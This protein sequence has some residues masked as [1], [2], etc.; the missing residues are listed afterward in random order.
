[1]IARQ[2]G[3]G[4]IKR[5]SNQKKGII[6][7][8]FSLNYRNGKHPTLNGKESLNGGEYCGENTERIKWHE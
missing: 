8:L 4:N 2:R 6:V 1:M 3:E 5:L 7:F